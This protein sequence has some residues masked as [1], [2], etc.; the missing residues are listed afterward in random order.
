MGHVAAGY[1]RVSR[2]KT[3]HGQADEIIS[4]D[5]QRE[6]FEK[7]AQMR[8]WDLSMV[9]EDLDYSGY[10]I[11][12]SK[13][14][15]LMEIMKAA[16]EGKI[17]FLLIYK[18]SRLSR[19]LREFLELW[20]Y[21]EKRGVGLVSVTESID[22]SSPYG[23]AAMHMLAVFAQLQSDELSEY[24]SN[25]KHTQANQGIMPGSPA[26]Y[27][28]IR[29]G[30]KILADPSTFPFVQTM[31]EM[32]AAGKSAYAIGQWLRQQRAP[33]PNGSTWW[34]DQIRRILR[35]PVYIGKFRFGGKDL[36]GRHDA[37]MPEMLFYGAQRRMDER[38]SIQAAKRSRTLSGTICC[39][40]CGSTYNVHH[41]G[42]HAKRRG[43]QCRRRFNPGCEGPRIDALTLEE[44]VAKRIR[45]IAASPAS[46]SLSKPKR[47]PEKD[48]S[49]LENDLAKT[50]R[51]INTLFEDYHERRIITA[52]QFAE[53]N[54]D[55][56]ERARSL[57]AE[58]A[59][60]MASSPEA[61][62]QHFEAQKAAL[63]GLAAT[64]DNLG[65]EE[66]GELL[67]MIGLKLTVYAD[68]VDMELLGR[69]ESILGEP[70]V[71][72]LYF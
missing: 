28:T 11:H 65:E 20:D 29:K 34:D 60:L 51:M 4:P 40:I 30:G 67:R 72:T 8:G 63:G 12:Y 55:Y 69:K 35:N 13:R 45:Q 21:F 66:R 57:E 17:K 16:D 42:G 41:G 70:K 44:Q 62:A 14:P 18:I 56:L 3:K 24:I 2:D 9:R 37:L 59:L 10:R 27:G 1:V 31:F 68:R 25:T 19:R 26:P 52:E 58:L 49:R 38:K 54:R 53:K 61:E 43:Y 23:R 36:D 71:S 5:T 39:G 22:T 50:R 47:H 33:A 46:L 7:Y 48:R 15:G 32:A 64:W 6:F